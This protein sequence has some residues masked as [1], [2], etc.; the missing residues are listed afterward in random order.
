MPCGYPLPCPFQ[1]TLPAR[2]SD[3]KIAGTR[4]FKWDISIHAPRK[5]E[6][7]AKERY[8]RIVITFQSTLPARG[9]DAPHS[10]VLR[11]QYYFNPRSPQG[12]ATRLNFVK[13]QKTGDFNPRSPQGGATPQLIAQAKSMMD[14]NPRSPQGGATYYL[15]A[16]F[17]FDR[18]FQSTL[19]A[20]GSDKVIQQRKTVLYHFNPRSP[21]GGATQAYSRVLPRP[22]YFNPRSPQG[23]AT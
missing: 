11:C 2:G 6:R 15:N 13:R 22:R 7:P 23:G 8:R 12:G 5:G 16:I 10:R 3:Q 21:Q 18:K 9:S 4:A 1:S 14:F 20:R 19:P 17:F